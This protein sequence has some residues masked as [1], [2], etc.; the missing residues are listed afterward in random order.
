M[1]DENDNK[2]CEKC[3]KELGK[4]KKKEAKEPAIKK[5]IHCDKCTHHIESLDLFE[6]KGLNYHKKCYTCVHCKKEFA[7]GEE[8]FKDTKDQVYF[9]MLK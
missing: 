4:D 5:T 9:D 8:V 3:F 7:G 2:L 1:K 6:T